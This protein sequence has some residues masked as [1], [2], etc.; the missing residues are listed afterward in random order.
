MDGIEHF[1][2][3][4]FNIKNAGAG[5]KGGWPAG[6]LDRRFQ[7]F[8][9]FCAPNIRAQ[10]AADFDWLLMCDPDTDPGD[11]DRLKHSDQGVR[12]AFASRNRGYMPT[13]QVLV[14]EDTRI[15][16]TTRLDSDDA[17]SLGAV[18]R[19][20]QALPAFHE[21]GADRML[22][23]FLHGYKLDVRT[24]TAY[25]SRMPNSAFAT[26]FELVGEEHE[27]PVG[28]MRYG[29]SDAHRQ[30]PTVQEEAMPGWLQVIHG[31]NVSNQ[32]GPA[33]VPVA[34]AELSQHFAI[35]A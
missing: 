30:L 22:F 5:W 28:V 9:Q 16:L 1:I 12:I 29:H 15:V 20:Q 3:T 4:R 34:S 13:P 14:R 23:N 18:E 32:I 33:D 2:I 7:L 35:A 26:L 11:L 6:W 8:E 10:T 24:G 27:P 19:V 21:S 17:L 25:R 31:G